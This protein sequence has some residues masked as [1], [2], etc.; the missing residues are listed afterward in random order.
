MSATGTCAQ[1]L[2]VETVGPYFEAYTAGYSDS[3]LAYGTLE[4]EGPGCTEDVIVGGFHTIDFSNLYYNPISPTTT[5][6]AGCAPYVNP[7][8]SMALDLTAAVPAWASCQPLYYGAFDPP[9]FLHRQSQ[10]APPA[11]GPGPVTNVGPAAPT[12]LPAE[13]P[14]APTPKDP[15]PTPA[16]APAPAPKPPQPPPQPPPAPAVPVDTDPNPPADP[17]SA[18]GNPAAQSDPIPPSDPG[19]PPAAPP[20]TPQDPPPNTPV[21]PPTEP[22]QPAPANTPYNPNNLT[23]AQVAALDQALGN[24]NPAPSDPAPDNPA[25]S[26]PAPNNPAPNDPVP[27]TPAPNNPA[28]NNPVPNNPAPDN[29]APN[30]PAPKNPAPNNLAPNNPAPVNPAPNNPAPT[31]IPLQTIPN[32]PPAASS[33]P[34]PQAPTQLQA[35]P[36]NPPTQGNSP[37]G[38]QDPTTPNPNPPVVTNDP[39]NGGNPTIN[40][41]QPQNNG[42]NPPTGANG[43]PAPANPPQPAAV[44]NVPPQTGQQPGPNSPAATPAVALPIATAPVYLGTTQ[45]LT[46]GGQAVQKAPDGG[47]LIGGQSLIPGTQ[48]T[49]AGQVVSVG[50]SNMAVGSSTY[51]LPAATGPNPV[52]LGTPAPLSIGGQAAQYAPGPNGGLLI[53][54]Q[55]IAAGQQA[56]VSGSVISVRASA[57]TVGG[58]TYAL[59][60]PTAAATFGQPAP[61]AIGGQAIQQAPGGGVIVAGQTITQGSQAIVQGTVVSVG[62][63]GLAIGGN[64]YAL[65]ILTAPPT[66]GGG[67]VLQA[68]GGGVILAGQTIA[69]GS[70]A[71]VQGTVVSVGPSGVMI[72]GNTYAIPAPTVAGQPVQ[73]APGGGVI[74]AG[75]TVAEGSRTTISGTIISVGPTGVIIAGSSY[76]IPTPT[77]PSP[78]EYIPAPVSIGN[79]PISQLPNSALLI[80]GQTLTPGATTTISGTAITLN[81]GNVVLDGST[82]FLPSLA[83]SASAPLQTPA[84]LLIAG[85]YASEA[86]SGGIILAGQTLAPGAQTTVSGTTISV[87]P[88]GGAVIVNGIT[89]PLL[90]PTSPTTSSLPPVSTNEIILTAGAIIT[91]ANG[92]I[93]TYTGPP[94]SALLEGNSELVIGTATFPLS[95]TVTGLPVVSEKAVLAGIIYSALGSDGSVHGGGNGTGMSTSVGTAAVAGSA[96]PSGTAGAGGNLPTV[97]GLGSAESDAGRLRK[98]NSLFVFVVAL[99]GVGVVGF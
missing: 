95:G 12:A 28:P 73:Q 68:P 99:V 98:H 27:N 71:T 9:S 76:N 13:V 64:N 30:N 26:N 7:R 93:A 29:P 46:I 84:P 77:S 35:I 25:P 58:S 8:V 57:L 45:P 41:G 24:N 69:Q 15:A 56:T 32:S 37:P 97:V 60:A 83:G 1:G 17:I 38:P 80:D 87:P 42:N 4:I 40:P 54:G 55:T 33:V 74:V 67:P 92:Q 34:A 86:P 3:F 43:N 78:L 52:A 39:A 47:I 19:K 49:V 81:A 59:P 20:T 31:P 89:Q 50:A 23:P 63:S 91:N 96:T 10:L 48:A 72:A 5:Y 14:A 82:F 16:P 70:Q 21:A 75:Q 53:A 36:I 22:G 88:T 61:P 66:V 44:N 90:N 79:A 65:P 94:L 85:T 2:P 51:A 11:A 62:P 18:P 6:K